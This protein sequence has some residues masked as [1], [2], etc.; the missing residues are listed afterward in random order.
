MV[1]EEKREKVGIAGYIWFIFAVLFFSGAFRDAPGAL[2]LLDLNTYLGTFGTIVEGA[3]PGFVG[4]GGSGLNDLFAV[5]LTIV[6]G[7]MFCMG[8]IEVVDHYGGLRAAGRLLTP[9]LK[10]LMGVPGESA[11][12]LIANL[13]SSDGS[14]ALIKA[15]RDSGSINQKQQNILL[16]YAMPGPALLGM[17]VSY[18]VMFYDYLP[19]STGIIIIVVLA[20]KVVVA[21]LMRFVISHGL[22]EKKKEGV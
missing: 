10:P 1:T 14:A 13:Q 20:M 7:I 6:P 11:L 18:G 15:L 19:C 2:K 4:Q 5:V 17:M 22:K 12:V 16:A 21:E 3:K 9:I 8:V